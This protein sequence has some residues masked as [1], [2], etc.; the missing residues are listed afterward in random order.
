[1]KVRA[2]WEEQRR[3]AM[4][5]G[6]GQ[7]DSPARCGWKGGR[8]SP[9]IGGEDEV[10]GYRR[11]NVRTRVRG[12]GPDRRNTVWAHGAAGG[13]RGRWAAHHLNGVMS[14]ES[15]SAK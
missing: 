11:A 14:G 5:T 13:G 10:C 7:A 8:G 15:S 9:A 1:M 3:P 2:Y 6:I 12:R 4:V